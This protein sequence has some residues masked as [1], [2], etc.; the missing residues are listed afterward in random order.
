MH[1]QGEPGRPPGVEQAEGADPGGARAD[2]SHARHRRESCSATAE[3]AHA[4]GPGP[5]QEPAP[6]QI[7]GPV[8]VRHP[9]TFLTSRLQSGL[10]IGGKT[11]LASRTGLSHCSHDCL[12]SDCVPADLLSLGQY[13]TG[14]DFCCNLIALSNKSSL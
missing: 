14:L 1:G 2:F 9:Q 7:Q 6:A 12:S 4:Q 8:H 3:A 5:H 10:F 13:R 11:H